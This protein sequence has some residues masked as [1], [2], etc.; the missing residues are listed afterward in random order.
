MAGAE[1]LNAV[2]SARAVGAGGT[3]DG[4]RAVRPHVTAVCVCA[5]ACVRRGRGEEIQGRGRERCGDGCLMRGLCE[6][7]GVTSERMQVAKSE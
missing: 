4:H 1:L 5:C 3:R 6:S 2:A 7:E